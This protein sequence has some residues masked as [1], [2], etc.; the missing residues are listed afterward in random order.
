MKLTGI[1]FCFKG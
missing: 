1:Y